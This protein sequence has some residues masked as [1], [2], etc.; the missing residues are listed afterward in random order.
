MLREPALNLS[1]YLKVKGR[2]WGGEELGF[3]LT[4]NDTYKIFPM[5]GRVFAVEMVNINDKIIHLCDSR[6]KKKEVYKAMPL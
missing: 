4:E 5:T 3:T 2:G 1:Q 6:S